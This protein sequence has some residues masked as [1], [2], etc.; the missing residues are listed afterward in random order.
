MATTPRP[1]ES[2]KRFVW[3]LLLLLAVGGLA[4][5]LA[6][7]LV[8]AT[9]FRQWRHK[10][11]FRD[12]IVMV[13]DEENERTALKG[14]V[15]GFLYSRRYARLDALIR[16]LRTT[17]AAFANGTPKLNVAYQAMAGPDEEWPDDQW[18]QALDRARGWMKASP[19]A[20]APRLAYADLLISYAWVPRG[21]GA[22]ED[23]SPSDRALH[24]QRLQE[25]KEA[26]TAAAGLAES[27]PRRVVTLTRLANSGVVPRAEL[28]AA[29]EQAVA[30][31]PEFQ[32]TYSYYLRYLQ[33]NR[34]G[35][36]GE[37]QR[38]L[39]DLARQPGGAERVA[40]AMWYFDETGGF[41]LEWAPWPVVKKGFD[42][43][44]ARHPDSLEVKSAACLFA[45]Y[46]HDRDET[47][48][49]LDELGTRMSTSVWRTEEK[50]VR[51]YLWAT[52]EQGEVAGGDPLARFFSWVMG[53]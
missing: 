19:E 41:R 4:V 29:Y 11:Q 45:S 7:G 8:G 9:Y 5:A 46:Y 47:R 12:A 23:L 28:T 52:F 48:R 6:V 44:R 16:E 40:R 10:T 21:Q 24:D 2:S 51:A 36:P 18:A 49:R 30:A 34:S 15:L 50:F 35:A 43:M 25:A 32:P 38:A 53:S 17:R 31:D 22:I 27:C 33:P 26:M 13:G 3:R 37:L 42:E 20:I 14:E 39:A 1:Q